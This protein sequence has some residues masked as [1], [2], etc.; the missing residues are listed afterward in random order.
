MLTGATGFLGYH[1]ARELVF[2]GHSVHAIARAS[3]TRPA[4]LRVTWF[5][6]DVRDRASLEPAI[7]GCDIVVH[8]AAQISFTKRDAAVQRAIN[9]EGTRNL[10]SLA[11]KVGVKRFLHTSSIAAIG[12]GEKATIDEDTRY[13]WPVGM[14]YNES[15]RDSERLVRSSALDTVCLNPA[16]VFGPNEVS[17][18]TLNLFRNVRRLPLSIVPPGGITLCD[19]RDVARAHV[20]AID[21]ARGRRG[22]RY[23]LG[24]PQLSYRELVGLVASA[25]GRRRVI[26]T[27]P[28]WPIRFGRTV[29]SP[30]ERLG[31]PI[32]ISLLNS[33]LS[34]NAYSSDKAIRE[35]GYQSRPADQ[36]IA[37][38]AAWYRAQHLL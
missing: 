18:R 11:E 38:S 2:A 15:K 35:L 26:A 19:V 20:A 8:S 27:L 10:L 16:V 30:F 13:D 4:D 36:I 9:V 6:G 34:T 5:E 24:G 28:A 22:E 7:A 1:V 37:D 25:L 32:P 23:I 14:Y 33:V 12:R 21:P 31:A 29:L 3:S 17:K